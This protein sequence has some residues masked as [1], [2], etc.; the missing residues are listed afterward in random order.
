MKD[1]FDGVYRYKTFALEALIPPRAEGD[2]IAVG[3]DGEMRATTYVAA[4]QAGKLVWRK[5]QDLE[6]PAVSSTVVRGFAP[7][8]DTA[9]NTF[10]CPKCRASR[11]CQALNPVCLACGYQDPRR[12]ELP[13]VQGH[14]EIIDPASGRPIGPWNP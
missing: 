4:H 3:T 11:D 2:L 8:V 6:L 9:S 7:G 1:L 10:T 12:F 14:Y 5:L 13:V